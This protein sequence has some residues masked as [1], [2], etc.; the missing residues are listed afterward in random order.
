MF[1]SIETFNRHNFIGVQI[2]HL[3]KH[4]C[5][6]ETLDLGDVL[7]RDEDLF[8]HTNILLVITHL[9]NFITRVLILSTGNILD[10]IVPMNQLCIESLLLH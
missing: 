1:A 5:V 4:P 3:D 2:D 10:E 6:I 7:V 9:N 8:R